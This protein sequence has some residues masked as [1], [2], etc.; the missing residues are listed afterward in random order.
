L[1]TVVSEDGQMM[2]EM[3]LAVRNNARQ[4]LEITL[5][6]GATNVWSAFVGGQP[7]RPSRRDGKVLLPMERSSGD[8]TVSVELTYV[9][10]DKFPAVRGAVGLASPALDVPLKNARWEL[11]LPPDY[12]YRKFEGTMKH[13]LAAVATALAAKPMDQTFSMH[14]YAQ[15]EAKNKKAREEDVSSSLSNARSLLRDNNLNDAYQNYNRA[16]QN[17]DVSDAP[18]NELVQQM[19]KELRQ[20]QARNFIA[21]NNTIIINNGGM[22]QGQ[23]TINAPA[24][25]ETA[26]DRRAAPQPAGPQGGQQT[27]Q[28]QFDQE[29][30]EQQVDKV[31]QAQDVTVAKTLPLRVNLPKRGVHIAFSQVLQT[32]IGK[33]MSV[34]FKAVNDRAASWPL[35]IGASLAGLVVLWL[36][37]ALTPRKRA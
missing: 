23:P 9:A 35:R 30:A 12:R 4:Y 32:E 27:V 17:I 13:E 7:V 24:Q 8:A 36:A 26:G 37:V 20:T 2:T 29:A 3:V 21:G 31:A 18:N 25:M 14:E 16:K 15:A 1:T 33:P 22:F 34:Q 5:P 10:A 6:Q 19:G 11:Y 28:W